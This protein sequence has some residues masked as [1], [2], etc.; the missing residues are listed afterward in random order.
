MSPRTTSICSLS[1]E[2]SSQPHDPVE[3]YSTN[4]RVRAPS[5]V[6]LSVRWLPM[7][8]PA[9]VTRTVF[10]SQFK[11]R[12]LVFLMILK[13]SRGYVGFSLIVLARLSD[14][15]PVFL[16]WETNNGPGFLH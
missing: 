5:S 14:I 8:P 4:A 2:Q 10:L 6:S 1:S 3:L 15:K 12:F 11:I 7:N 16:N 9:P 13:A